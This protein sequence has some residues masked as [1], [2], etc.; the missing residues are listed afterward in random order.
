ML[1]ELQRAMELAQQQ[2]EDE[3]R[4]I[5]QLI[6]EE[7]EDREWEES[8]ELAAATAEAHAELAN[9]DVMDFEEY[10]RARNARERQAE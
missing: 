9:G 4:R 2:P 3:Q 7:L 8:A 5:A 1:D 10:D 6:L